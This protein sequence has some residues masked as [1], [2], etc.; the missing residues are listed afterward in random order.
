MY[1]FFL[2]VCRSDCDLTMKYY[3]GHVR[4]YVTSF[5]VEKDTR[6]LC[7][8]P[9]EEIQLEKGKLCACSCTSTDS[10]LLCSMCTVSRDRMNC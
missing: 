10:T 7:R 6:A 1:A 8:L 9:A 5:Q 4:D 2:L 3:A